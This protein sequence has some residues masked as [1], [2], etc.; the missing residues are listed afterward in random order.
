MKRALGAKRL[1]SPVTRSSVQAGVA[2]G[3]VEAA[4]SNPR[5]LREFCRH[6][7]HPFVRLNAARALLESGKTSD[8]AF[9]AK[10]ARDDRDPLAPMLR[11]ALEQARSGKK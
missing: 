6:E 1:T 7:E 2:F 10:L 4:R 11:R 8:R 3:L 9:V 5:A